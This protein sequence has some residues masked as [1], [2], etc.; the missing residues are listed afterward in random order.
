MH[1]E[2]PRDAYRWMNCY[3]HSTM[4]EQ[5]PKSAFFT[6]PLPKD[7]ED[8]AIVPVLTAVEEPRLPLFALPLLEVYPK[9]TCW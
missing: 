8:K 5:G 9:V 1:S 7:D 3:F 2:S 6:P 4:G